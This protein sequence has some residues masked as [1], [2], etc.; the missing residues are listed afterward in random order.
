MS[1]VFCGV[2]WLCP[3]GSAKNFKAHITKRKG[4]TQAGPFLLVHFGIFQWVTAGDQLMVELVVTNR[5]R[6]ISVLA[7]EIEDA[8][9]YDG[10]LAEVEAAGSRNHAAAP[11]PTGVV[12]AGV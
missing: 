6:W 10:P 12:P 3:A 2:T 9:R 8:C 4:P 11:V 7:L 1:G 5:R